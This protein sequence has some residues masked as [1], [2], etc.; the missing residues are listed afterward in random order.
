MMQAQSCLRTQM[1]RCLR[2]QLM[3][4]LVADMRLTSLKLAQVSTPCKCSCCCKPTICYGWRL[5]TWYA[6]YSVIVHHE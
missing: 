5:V 4:S 2:T 3:V 6:R 1:M